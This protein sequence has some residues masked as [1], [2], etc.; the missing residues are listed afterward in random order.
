MT[1][2][3][4]FNSASAGQ[5]FPAVVRLAQLASSS[6]SPSASDGATTTD[7]GQSKLELS[8]QAAQ[9][10]SSLATLQTQAN[11]LPAGELSLKDQDWLIE[12]LEAEL[13]K[14][15]NDLATMAKLTAQA[16]G[17]EAENSEDAEMKNA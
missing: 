4:V 5:I 8:K 15:R 2:E 14:K 9:L 17:I 13:T 6:S 11:L 3:T 1:A 12:Q 10:R 16:N 7:A